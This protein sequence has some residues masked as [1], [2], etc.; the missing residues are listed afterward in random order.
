MK[1]NREVCSN[2]VSSETSVAEPLSKESEAFSF[3]KLSKRI[4]L[5][6][7]KYGMP[8]SQANKTFVASADGTVQ[9][10][11]KQLLSSNGY[12]KNSRTKQKKTRVIFI[13]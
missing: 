13:P 2:L 3:K 10:K 1:I 6:Q 4:D 11:D 12:G 5:I 9:I 8:S 7:A